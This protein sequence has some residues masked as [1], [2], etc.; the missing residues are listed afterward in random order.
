[1]SSQP[2]TI[3]F[4][5]RE[6]R[7]T[8]AQRS[9][10]TVTVP[11]YV[12]EAERDGRRETQFAVR[13]G[14]L[15]AGRRKALLDRRRAGLDAARAPVAEPGA[16]RDPQATTLEH[17]ERAG[18]FRRRVVTPL[19]L[20]LRRG[21]ITGRQHEAGRKLRT[22][23]EIL[24]GATDGEPGSGPRIYEP[25]EARLEATRFYRRALQA[26]GAIAS[27]LVVG[28]VIEEV[29]L[30]ETATRAGRRRATVLEALSGALDAIGD[31]YGLPE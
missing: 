26:A 27:P 5:G 22:S 1:M 20:L 16:W 19:D 3:R 11:V 14:V 18:Q 23:W 15:D 2:F 25:A 17:T 9:R 28:V 13:G 4:G 10:E 8:E 7:L 21:S 30:R 12:F 31:V 29:S 24:Q 6:V